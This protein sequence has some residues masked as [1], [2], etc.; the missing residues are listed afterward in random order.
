V[1]Q[2]LAYRFWLCNRGQDLHATVA[3]RTCQRVCQEH[4]FQ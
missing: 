1:V 2:N 3:L 4:A